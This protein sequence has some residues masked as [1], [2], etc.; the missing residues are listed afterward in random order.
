MLEIASHS[1]LA[2]RGG[3]STGQG[4]QAHGLS[5]VFKTLDSDLLQVVVTMHSPA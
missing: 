4:L 2:A 1:Q 3:D 5:P